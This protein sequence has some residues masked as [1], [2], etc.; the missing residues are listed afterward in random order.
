MKHSSGDKAHLNGRHAAL[1]RLLPVLLLALTVALIS[2]ATASAETSESTV[3]LEAA[4]EGVKETERVESEI[5]DAKAAEQLPHRDLDRAQALQ[6]LSSV[7]GTQ[8]EGVAGVFGS[9]NVEHFLSDNAAVID[10]GDQSFGS[11]VVFGD[12]RYEGP[13]LIESMVPLLTE[14][15]SGNQALVDLEL[16]PAAEEELQPANPLVEVSVPGELGEGINLPESE[17]QID[18]AGAPTERSPSLIGGSAAVYPEVAED[19]TFAVAPSPTGVETFTML[20]SPDAPL[21]QTYRLDLTDG[22]A[23]EGTADGGAEVSQEGEPLLRIFPPTAL[24]AE[25][26]SVP[27]TM[28]AEGDSFTLSAEPSESAAYPLLIDPIMEE[29]KWSLN[30]TTY[31]L[32]TDWQGISTNQ[33]LLYNMKSATGMPG[34]DIRAVN[35]FS[36]N[37]GG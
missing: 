33:G 2:G 12:D 14:D 32:G 21:S 35:G 9:L 31:G 37:A 29:Y 27:V 1:I 19:T 17:I 22:A 24:D 13:A 30:N 10:A 8:I 5:T 15:E 11:G 6:L 36:L 7:F 4:K 28:S 25:G 3:T 34:S 18:L 20:Q 23:L 26:A 16:E